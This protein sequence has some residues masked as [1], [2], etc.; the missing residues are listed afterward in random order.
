MEKMDLSAYALPSGQVFDPV[1]YGKTK[2]DIYN[3]TEGDLSG[4]DCEKC[5]NK[6]RVAYLREDAGV[7]FWECGCMPSR[8]SVW[9]MEKSG[10]KNVI[11]EMTFDRFLADH[12][13]QQQIKAQAMAYAESMEGWLLLCGQ[14]GSGK[15]HLCTAICR[16]RLLKGD[17]VRYM[18]WRDEVAGLKAVSLDAAQRGKLLEGLKTAPIL[19]VDDLFK[20]ARTADGTGSPTAAD[21][22]IAF[23]IINY[24]YINHLATLVSTEKL[25]EEL[26]AIDEATGS[27][28][29]ER[30][31]GNILTVN[32]NPERNHR[33]RDVVAV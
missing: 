16:E 21:I 11:R 31:R 19:Y 30:A 22:G 10:L 28:I 13:W 4:M 8:R 9:R 14:V 20:T 7:G 12:P 18:P 3:R 25:P 33:L 32:R 17:E 6:G 2:V 23:E 27:R 15:T 29:L 26:L 5:R 24:R 1:A